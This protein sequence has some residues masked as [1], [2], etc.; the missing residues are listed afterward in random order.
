MDL[1]SSTRTPRACPG[2]DKPDIGRQKEHSGL[3][4]RQDWL[5]SASAGHD[6]RM[7]SNLLV[8]LLSGLA[9]VLLGVAAGAG[10]SLGLVRTALAKRLTERVLFDSA[11]GQG[12]I[13][14]QG[15]PEAVRR[16]VRDYESVDETQL[17]TS[18]PEAMRRIATSEAELA[19]GEVVS[20]DELAEAMRRRYASVQ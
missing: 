7:D 16:L 17:I 15:S 11:G 8:G 1:V 6:R 19:A 20:R 9:G 3:V 4:G 18:D 14:V 5:E 13:T 12:L 10:A 2:N